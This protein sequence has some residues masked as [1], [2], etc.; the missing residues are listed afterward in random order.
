MCSKEPSHR[1]SS[2]EYPQHMFWMKN[3]E[4]SFQI[5]TLTWRPGHNR[6]M[7]SS[8]PIKYIF[9]HGNS[10]RE[11]VWSRKIHVQIMTFTCC[12]NIAFTWKSLNW[13]LIC[14]HDVTLECV[15]AVTDHFTNAYVHENIARVYMTW[16][17]NDVP[18]LTLPFCW[19]IKGKKRDI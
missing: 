19:K 18:K 4:N 6:E 5:H 1:G 13:A 10:L 8:N 16:R 15:S 14:M 3:K 17:R 9:L 11:A 2:F 7:T 12:L